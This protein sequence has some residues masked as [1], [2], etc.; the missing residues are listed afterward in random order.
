[1]T[2]RNSIPRLR[3]VRLKDGGAEVHVMRGGDPR[4]G[5]ALERCRAVVS[6][7]LRDG[8]EIAGFAVVVWG[9]FGE[10]T[11]CMHCEDGRPFPSILA[12]DFVRNRL[13]ADRIERWT[14]E[15][16]FPPPTPRGA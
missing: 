5:F 4:A 8:A 14:L 9:T 15:T 12:P 11:C 16:V 2:E 6:Q 3:S 1:M 7:H 13:L 10:S